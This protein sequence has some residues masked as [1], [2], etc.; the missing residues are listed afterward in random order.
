MILKFF[1][2][3]FRLFLIF[4]ICFIWVRYFVSSLELT[5]AISAILTVCFEIII[6]FFLDKRYAKTKLKADEEKL[7]EKISSNFV[8]NPKLATTYFL[9]L[10]KINYNA[11]KVG[12]YIEI[13]N[14]G[15]ESFKTILFPLYSYNPLSAQDVVE[16][17]KKTEKSKLSKIVVCSYKVS[18]EAHEISKKFSDFKIF[19]LD[20]KACFSKLIKHYN[21]YPENL[22]EIEI[23]SKPKFKE[24]L[25]QALSKSRAKGYLVASL[26]LLFSSFIVRMN[27]YYVVFSSILLLLSLWSFFFPSK[28]N[29]ADE[30]IL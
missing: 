3:L 24:I 20:S 15:E 8:L 17:I 1:N 13:T 14:K 18:K 19:L 26:V 7:A 22:K 4:L 27:I 23:I 29:Y 10:A 16:I 12:S 30:T 28:P 25:K 6:H 5:L 21:F 2:I 9:N 11:K